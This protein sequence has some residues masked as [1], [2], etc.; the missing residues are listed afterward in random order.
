MK[1]PVEFLRAL[2]RA[3]DLYDIPR[4][5]YE[6]VLVSCMPT[7][8]IKQWVE[9]HLVGQGHSWAVCAAKFIKQYMP[10]DRYDELYT[11]LTQ[12]RQNSLSPSDFCEQFRAQADKLGI[13]D[14]NE[15]IVRMMYAALNRD[16]KIELAR[17]AA[18]YEGS[19]D[20]DDEEGEDGLNRGQGLIY[21]SMT[22]LEQDVRRLEGTLLRYRSAHSARGSFGRR[23]GYRR[24]V[25]PYVAA[26]APASAAAPSR[27]RGRSRSARR[28]GHIARV[29][30]LELSQDG[31]PAHASPAPPTFAPRGRGGSRGRGASR[32]R[33][34][35][36]TLNRG[37]GRSSTPS[38]GRSA[39]SDGRHSGHVMEIRCYNCGKLG[40]KSNVCRSPAS[41]AVE[42]KEE[43]VCVPL[44]AACITRNV[45]RK[46]LL[47]SE[48][49]PSH[50]FDSI[51]TDTGAQFSSISKR[52]VEQ[53]NLT[54][55]PPGVSA[56]SVIAGATTSM[57]VPRLGHVD[58]PLTVHFPLD[59]TRQ[60]CSYVSKRFEVMEMQRDFIFG[61]DLI[62]TLFPDDELLAYLGPHSSI[63]DAPSVSSA[64]SDTTSSLSPHSSHLFIPEFQD[65][66][67]LA[68]AFLASLPQSAAAS[69][70]SSPSPSP[71][72]SSSSDSTHH[73][74]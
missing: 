48:L 25:A 35:P 33:G 40:H 31:Q 26:A 46:L 43:M 67:S 49:L 9:R 51:L 41:N 8:M 16:I 36:F 12:L 74:Q 63:T 27:G 55:S 60:A 17:A 23:G 53:F 7:E 62:G 19:I 29:N 6:R 22:K 39:P 57:R 52:V 54:I 4:S 1:D 20:G 28:G 71:S 45:R 42:I 15:V 10:H 59:T 21:A 69:S 38:F 5:S 66:E 30:R 44:S 3:F 37:R 24:R 72:L 64:S 58:L 73:T 11:E 47:T 13:A 56:P 32:G 34:R 70:S 68:A 14:D 18:Y 50:S 61:V 65:G 2:G